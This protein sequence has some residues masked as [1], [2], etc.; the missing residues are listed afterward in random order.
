[1]IMHDVFCLHYRR[2]EQFATSRALRRR[3]ER[4]SIAIV[5]RRFFYQV[6]IHQKL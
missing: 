5:D 2:N 3:I 1:M 6:Q 4:H